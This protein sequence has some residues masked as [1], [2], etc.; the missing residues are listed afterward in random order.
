M[1]WATSSDCQYSSGTKLVWTRKQLSVRS[2]RANASSDAGAA[3]PAGARLVRHG[4][5]G[6]RPPALPLPLPLPARPGPTQPRLPAPRCAAAPPAELYS[7]E[8]RLRSRTASGI[9]ARSC[10]AACPA[11]CPAGACA[12]AGGGTA[13]VLPSG[14]CSQREA[15]A[16]LY[17]AFR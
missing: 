1:R 15:G 10:P 16:L 17:P 14:A 13:P 4:P 9:R 2:A 11:A 8:R 6:G 3:A 7:T 12:T 5:L